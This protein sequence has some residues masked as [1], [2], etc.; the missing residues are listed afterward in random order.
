MNTNYVNYIVANTSGEQSVVAVP[1][2]VAGKFRKLVE[3]KGMRIVG[4]RQ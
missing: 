2:I 1:R 3:S 4:I